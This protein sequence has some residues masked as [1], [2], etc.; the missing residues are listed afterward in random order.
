MA[1]PS[2]PINETLGL[3]GF[4]FDNT[5]RS[6]LPP[7]EACRPSARQRPAAKVQAFLSP[8]TSAAALQ[9]PD[10][11]NARSEDA[12]SEEDRHN[13]C[14]HHLQG[15]LQQRLGSRVSDGCAADSVALAAAAG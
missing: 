9:E 13:H 4:N 6:V 8:P 1:A 2:A 11:W 15:V 14:G 3:G 12:G 10:V 7:C 5:R